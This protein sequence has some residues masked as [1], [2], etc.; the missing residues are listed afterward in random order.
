MRRLEAGELTLD[1]LG[2]RTALGRHGSLIR[3]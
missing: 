3:P 1:V 2:F